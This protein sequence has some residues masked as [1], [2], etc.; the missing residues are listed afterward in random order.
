MHSNILTFEQIHFQPD[1]ETF[2]SMRPLMSLIVD[3]LEVK[4]LPYLQRLPAEPLEWV[5]MVPPVETAGLEELV[6]TLMASIWEMDQ[7]RGMVHRMDRDH[8]ELVMIHKLEH[9]LHLIE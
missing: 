5:L 7:C 8:Q 2:L 3:D 4:R 9:Q 6:L 1:L